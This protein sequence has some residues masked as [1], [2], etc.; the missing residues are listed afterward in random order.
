M[1]HIMENQLKVKSRNGRVTEW[2]DDKLYH[3]LQS[4]CNNIDI[5]HSDTEYIDHWGLMDS[6]ELPI[7]TIV[8]YVK[9]Q[10]PDVTSKREVIDIVTD[11]CSSMTTTDT[12][13][14]HLSS[15]IIHR[16]HH[17]ETLSSFVETTKI[18]WNCAGKHVISESYYNNVMYHSYKLD[19]II[20]H[21]RDNLIDYF[22]FKTLERAYLLKVNGKIVERIQHLWMR[23]A[24]GLHKRDM[25]KIKQTYTLLSL[26]YFIHATPTL[27]N[28]GTPNPQMSSCYLVSLED[29]SISGIFNTLSEC[30]SISKWAG[31]IGLHIHNIRGAGTEIKGTNGTSN[32]IVPMLRVFNATARYVDQ[33]GGRRNG[34]I[35]IYME[36][37]H[38][39][40]YELI[41]MKRNQ[42]DDELRA[43]DLF[44][45]LWVPDLFMERV[46]NNDEWSLFSPDTAPDLSEL[47]GYKFNELYKQY[48]DE[49]RAIRKVN[50]REL[51]L[52]I[53]DSQME[54][55]TPYILYKDAANIKS[56]Q[57]NLGTIKSSNLC[58]EIMEYSSK[59]ETAVCNLS[60]ISLPNFVRNTSFDGVPIVYT[61]EQC[62]WCE[63]L[64]VLFK[65]RNVSFEE[66]RVTDENIKTIKSQLGIT[67][68]PRIYLDGVEIG[69]YSECESYLYPVFD[70]EKLSE[71]VE[72]VVCNLNHIIDDNL[73][74]TIKS[75]RSNLLHRPIGIGIQGLADVFL[76]MDL[77][78]DSDEANI[79]NVKIA[80]TIYYTALDMSCTLSE[81][82][83]SIIESLLKTET[84][85]TLFRN[86]NDPLSTSY[87]LNDDV[88][89]TNLINVCRPTLA[90]FTAALQGNPPGAYATFAG[91]PASNGMLQ[92]D[93]WGVTPDDRYDWASL[94]T[95][96]KKYGIR[97]SLLVAPMPT[98]STSQILGNNECFEPFTSNIYTR[99]TLSGEYI[100]VN[101]H[102]VDEMSAYGLWCDEMKDSIIKHNGSI[103][104]IQTIPKNVRDKYKTVWE[105]SMKKIIL[106]SASRGPY[107]CQSQS[108]NLWMA[109]PTY[110]T[111]TSMH[112]YAWHSGLKTGLYYL[113]RKPRHQVQQFTIAPENDKEDT[114]EMCSA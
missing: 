67:T 16:C 101:K 61:K 72:V 18:L 60:S 49:G 113:R 10:L 29:D 31:G 53:L 9:K 2:S 32:G 102:L 25:K 71:V 23:V 15:R 17:K 103:Q 22:G 91:C 114:C 34:S 109:S 30:A 63:R 69:G 97:N 73:Y 59:D 112:F 111:L 35:A 70:F 108:L 107:I 1:I 28:I 27:F 81:N 66:I 100:M 40:I 93:M 44:Y 75:K 64:K 56:N 90:E 92:F 79:L 58:T 106:M 37:W 33:G 5:Y 24:V 6:I 78:F 52:K 19:E 54:T 84:I 46:E 12:K 83:G 105:L 96:I 47:Y 98:A 88:K 36:P 62:I 39:D 43:R 50:A 26:K 41:D 86:P 11:Y 87:I 80:A 68:F 55:G 51:W 38:S 99:R 13:Y 74:P 8:D 77:P 65:R 110:R 45:A 42:G 57:Q 95:R 94:K 82:R 48:E 104:H 14:G 89:R 20:D 21:N 85:E 4:I 3:C 76:L 7:K